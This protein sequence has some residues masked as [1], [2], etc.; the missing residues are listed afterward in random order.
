MLFSPQ[1]LS[2]RPIVPLVAG[3]VNLLLKSQAFNDPAWTIGFQGNVTADAAVAPDS[4]TTADRLEAFAPGNGSAIVF[5][6]VTVTSGVAYTLS[7]YAKPAPVGSSRW[8][9]TRQEDDVWFDLVN[10]VV[11][12]V[13]GSAIATSISGPDAQG[14]YR[15]VTTYTTSGTPEQV[16]FMPTDNDGS[17][18]Y[19]GNSSNHILLWGAQ[20]EIGSSATTYVP[21]L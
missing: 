21:N 15:C 4:T 5:Q 16:G 17:G 14:Y 19:T 9:R 3:T 11:G 7:V 8:L 20:Y 18:A 12:T 6:N 1:I 13:S 2:R 10:G